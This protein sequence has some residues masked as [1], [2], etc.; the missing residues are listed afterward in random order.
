MEERPVR[1]G[2]KTRRVKPVTAKAKQ[3]FERLPKD[4]TGL[5]HVFMPHKIREQV[6]YDKVTEIADA[7]VLWRDEFT[8]DQFHYFDLLCTIIENYENY[9]TARVPWSG[10]TGS[11][12]LSH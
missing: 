4:F 10:V 2:G 6:D 7:M 8:E 9:D 5:C 11:E 1:I 3:R 12:M